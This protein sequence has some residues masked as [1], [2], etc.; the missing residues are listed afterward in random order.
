MLVCVRVFVCVC[1]LFVLL[2]VG[3]L[4]S[5]GCLSVVPPRLDCGVYVWTVFSQIE[6]HACA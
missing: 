6:A 2:R 1:F 5:F 4:F 3:V